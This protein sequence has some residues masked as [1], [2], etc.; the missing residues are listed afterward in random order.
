MHGFYNKILNIDLS[1]K[2]FNVQKINEKI[3]AKYL[4]GKGLASW[5]LAERNPEG[6]DPLGCDNHLIFATG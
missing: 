1:K 3:Y 6:V 4:G 5:L 2:E